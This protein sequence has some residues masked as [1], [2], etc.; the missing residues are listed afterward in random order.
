MLLRFETDSESSNTTS[1]T[2]DIYYKRYLP[3]LIYSRN[4]YRILITVCESN[5]YAGTLR[6]LGYSRVWFIVNSLSSTHVKIKYYHVSLFMNL[7][8]YL[9]FQ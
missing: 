4:S 1:C 9:F 5:N 7:N 6:I 8:F 3:K 2:T